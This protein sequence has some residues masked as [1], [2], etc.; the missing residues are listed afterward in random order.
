[1]AQALVDNAC[2]AGSE[3]DLL[4]RRNNGLLATMFSVN[5]SKTKRILV[6]LD[7]D[8]EL[9]RAD[10]YSPPNPAEEFAQNPDIQEV[11]NSEILKK[12]GLF[13]IP[14][15]VT[16]GNFVVSVKLSNAALKDLSWKDLVLTPEWWLGFKNNFLRIDRYFKD[17]GCQFYEQFFGEICVRFARCE[18]CI[19]DVLANGTAQ[20]R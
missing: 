19:I 1:M 4:V 6:E 5:A 15:L 3:A 9:N 11:P 13:T 10:E 17:N 16:S 2:N 7:W 12:L 20:R 14:A 18:L 8:F